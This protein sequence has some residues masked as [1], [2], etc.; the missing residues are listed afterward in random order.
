MSEEETKQPSITSQNELGIIPC[1]IDEEM[2][3][4]YLDYAMSVIIGRALPDARDGLKPVHRRILFAMHEMGMFHDKPYK[5]SARIVGEVLGKFH[6]HGDAAVYDSLVRMAQTFSLRYPLIDGHG[7]FGSVDGDSPASMRYTEARLQKISKELLEDIDKE[8]V[9]FI[10]N[11]DGSLQEPTVLPANL[12]N[13]LINGSSGIAVGMATNIP[14]HNIKE[15]CEGVIRLIEYKDTTDED[16][17][18]IIKGPDF[19]TGGIILGT[20]GIRQAYLSGR[21]LLKVRGKAEVEEIKNNKQIIITEIPYMVNK[22]MLIEQIAECVKEKTI[23]GISDLRDESDREGMR[24]V[25]ELKKDAEPEIVI[26]QLYKYSRLQTT[27]GMNM[28]ALINSEPKTLTLKEI[29]LCFIEHRKEVITKRTQYELK[30]AQ[31]RVHILEGLIVA[32]DNIDEAVTLIKNALSGEKARDELMNRYNLSKIQAQ[33]ILDMKLQRLTSLEQDKIRAETKDLRTRIL[34]YEDILGSEIRVLGMI[35]QDM[36]N[37]TQTYQDERKTEIMMW[38]DDEE[39]ITEDLIKPEEMVVTITHNGYIK[40]VPVETYK[41]QRRGGK[42]IIAT[43][44]KEED[45]VEDLFIANTHDTVLFF[46]SDG[47]VHWKRVYELPEGSRQA[48]GKAMVN[49]LELETGAKVTAFIA[50]KEF[51]PEHYLLM[52]TKQ[53]VIK[54]TSLD[55]YA[56]PRAGGIIGITLDPGDELVNVLRTDGK[57]QIVLA[58]KQ[59]MAI[60][61]NEEDARPIGRTSRGVRGIT[62]RKGD[63]VVGMVEGD[64]TKTILTITENGYGKRTTIDEYRLIN[65]GGVGVINIICSE[66]NGNVVNVKSVSDEDEVMLIS[67]NGIIIR[68]PCKDIS[69]IGRNT[70]GVR[71]MKLE[72]S[73]NVV[74]A[75]K[76]AREE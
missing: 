57:K 63:E 31:E 59:G 65:R 70:Q 33:A 67:K 25:I 30:K 5:K 3:Q 61:F 62:L 68:T 8:T 9:L 12:P 45:I 44:T 55:A 54:K 29:L 76:I 34:D 42:G 1:R 7:N 18:K 21:G 60:K 2:K 74:A 72:E 27:F 22:S 32:L 6:P 26:N 19:P 36:I 20:A 37:L 48:Q 40:R 47:I 41:Q 10:D 46:S 69:T 14:P 28:L 71:L 53:G 17:G 23:L 15:V 56:R 75:A 35:K 39:L 52:A 4:S 50:I 64:D 49:L 51:N 58:T 24:I 66:R 38:N 43:G 11:F 13:L 73:D 16:L